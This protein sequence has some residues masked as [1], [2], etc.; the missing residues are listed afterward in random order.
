MKNELHVRSE[1]EVHIDSRK[2]TAVD[3]RLGHAESTVGEAHI[4]G[5]LIVAAESDVNGESH[6]CLDASTAID[7]IRVNEVV[8][9]RVGFV[10]VGPRAHLPVAFLITFNEDVKRLTNDEFVVDPIV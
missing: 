8:D 1:P 5:I 4:P 6:F 7:L 10:H 3:Q 9:H 2:N